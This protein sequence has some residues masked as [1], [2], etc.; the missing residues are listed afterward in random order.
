[1]EVNGITGENAT[2]KNAGINGIEMKIK[3]GSWLK[4]MLMT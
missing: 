2:E 1:M 4:N 3:S